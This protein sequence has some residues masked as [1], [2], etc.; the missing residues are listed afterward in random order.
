[1]CDQGGSAAEVLP[2]LQLLE[3]FLRLGSLSTQFTGADFFVEVPAGPP[4]SGLT[5][6]DFFSFMS[7]HV[8]KGTDH[9]AA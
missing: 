4:T 7:V 9:A 5:R 1:M 2:V 8:T 6:P 3:R